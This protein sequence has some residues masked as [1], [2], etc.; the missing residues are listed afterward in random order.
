MVKKVCLKITPHFEDLLYS[1][2]QYSIVQYSI[3]QYDTVSVQYSIVIT[4]IC[5]KIEIGQI[6][7]ILF[8]NL[9]LDTNYFILFKKFFICKTGLNKNSIKSSTI[10]N[11]TCENMIWLAWERVYFRLKFSFSGIHFYEMSRR[12]NLCS[13]SREESSTKAKRRSYWRPVLPSV[14]LLE[15]YWKKW[16]LL[17]QWRAERF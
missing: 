13:L 3:V 9:Q 11:S 4:G 7:F 17:N 16:S 10:E 12:K 1:M 15:V 14:N 6:Y 5:I 8:E 2:V